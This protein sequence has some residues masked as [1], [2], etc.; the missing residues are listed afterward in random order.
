L[1]Y[2]NYYKSDENTELLTEF[3]P[4]ETDK[5]FA[6]FDYILDFFFYASIA[7]LILVWGI[8]CTD[9]IMRYVFNNPIAWAV[10]GTEYGLVLMAF[11]AASWLQREKGHTNIDIIIVYLP[12]KAQRILY[13]VTQILG[14]TICLIIGFF[15]AQA[16]WD[17]FQRGVLLAK[18]VEIPK[19]YLFV[20]IPLGAFLL[21]MQFIR[22]AYD[23]FR[24]G[25]SD[26]R[27]HTS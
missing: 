10:E 27:N 26:L 21:S 3:K 2:S 15:S 14:A 7:V 20:V 19:A 5:I 17:Q 23:Y 6:V 8:V 13:I 12:P 11:L 24:G 9:V 4:M 25:T 18:A 1:V 16:T 22:G